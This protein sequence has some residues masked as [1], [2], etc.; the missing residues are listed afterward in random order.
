[1][2]KPDYLANYLDYDLDLYDRLAYLADDVVDAA[3][4]LDDVRQE[5][6]QNTPDYKMRLLILA[7]SAVADCLN[8][9]SEH[10][11]QEAR[12]AQDTTT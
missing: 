5:I 2:R 1:M 6:G 3:N 9:E 11:L 7:L 12:K 8:A 4:L 10:L